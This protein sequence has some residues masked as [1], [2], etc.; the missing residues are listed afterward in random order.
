MIAN[1]LKICFAKCLAALVQMFY[2]TKVLFS[3]LQFIIQ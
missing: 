1:A 3:I 2:E